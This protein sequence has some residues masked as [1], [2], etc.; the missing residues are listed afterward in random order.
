[1]RHSVLRRLKSNSG[2]TMVGM[3]IS[4]VLMGLVSIS[5]MNFYQQQHSGY[6]QQADVTDTQ[7]SLRATMN[8]LTRLIRM[9]GYRANGAEAVQIS[10]GGRIIVLRYFDGKDV[11]AQAFYLLANVETGRNDLVTL[12]GKGLPTTFAEGI[13]SILFTPGGT[14]AGVRW[15]TVDLV[16]KT[17]SEG[18]QSAE[19]DGLKIRDAHLYRRLTSRIAIR[20]RS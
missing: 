2:F 4:A 12:V 1:M 9:A 15:V 13:D 20:N 5:A 3:M 16:A 11:T 14:G 8:E 6:L 17:A 7:Q 18:F 10:T 19:K